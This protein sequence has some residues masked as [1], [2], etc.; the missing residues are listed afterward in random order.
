[1]WSG[2]RAGS[3]APGLR[4]VDATMLRA[5][6]ARPVHGVPLFVGFG[7]LR[8]AV[9]WH[10]VGAALEFRHWEQFRDW[11]D[12]LPGGFLGAAVAGFF[13]NGGTHCAVV[14]VMF[15]HGPSDL[16]ASF[17]AGGPLEDIGGVDL[18][19]VPDAVLHSDRSDAALREIHAAAV[20]HCEAMGERLA[21]LDALQGPETGGGRPDDARI[22]AVTGQSHWLKSR[23]GALYFPWLTID[24]RASGHAPGRRVPP[25]GHVAGLYARTDARVGVHKAPAN[26][27]LEGTTALECEVDGEQH[28]RL[29]DAGVNCIRSSAAMGTRVWGARTLSGQSDWLYVPVSRL[30]LA[31]T[32]W[33]KHQV[34]DLVFETHTPELWRRVHRRLSGY[35]LDL[36]NAGALASMDAASAFFVKCDSENNPPASRDAGQLVADVGLAPSA[37]AEFVV[38]RITH[39]ANGIAVNGLQPA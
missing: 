11:I 37:P 28:G 14:P 30:F 22:A 12:P 31:L 25:C 13:A 24:G 39:G 15:G 16:I 5:T 38:V 20:A 19:C 4:F 3:R 7:R 27:R 34:D 18:L 21:I 6:A 9:A 8:R 10:P 29:N 35:C 32:G 36:M 26:E 23:F 1:M 2:G 17:R 33:L